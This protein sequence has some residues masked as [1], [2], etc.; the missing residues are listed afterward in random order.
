MSG[1][2][3]KEYHSETYK[4]E[5]TKEEIIWLKQK[6]IWKTNKKTLRDVSIYVQIGGNY[7]KTGRRLSNSISIFMTIL[8]IVS[9]KGWSY[10]SISQTK[11]QVTNK[12]S[13]NMQ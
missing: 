11:N 1:T 4:S 3:V 9:I 13:I 12:I 5:E 10:K 6:F 7:I 8:I 2:T